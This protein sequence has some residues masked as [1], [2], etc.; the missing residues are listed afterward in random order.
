MI[1]EASTHILDSLCIVL[2]NAYLHKDTNTDIHSQ[3]R[4]THLAFIRRRPAERE[5]FTLETRPLS[6]FFSNECPFRVTFPYHRRGD[7]GKLL[8]TVAPYCAS[9]MMRNCSKL[10]F[11]HSRLEPHQDNSLP[12]YAFRKV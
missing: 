1:E 11:K 9:V 3:I 6:V 4:H 2:P 5:L 10:T 7:F 8:F 12:T